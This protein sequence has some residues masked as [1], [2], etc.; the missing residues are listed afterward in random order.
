MKTGFFV[1]I[2][3]LLGIKVTMAQENDPW[4]GTWTSESYSDVDFENSPKDSRGTF[5]EIVYTKYKKVF[6]ITKTGDHYYVRGKTIKVNDSNYSSYHRPYTI[7]SIEGNT[8]RLIS[9]VTKSP[10]RVNGQID[11]YS[12]ITYYYKLTLTNGVLHYTFI[13][14][15]SIDYDKNMRYT[16]EEDYDASIYS[17]RDY[18]L[19]FFND[20]W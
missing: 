20:D 18:D 13:S 14:Y 11:S 8:M 2:L 15:H 6:R 3:S 16:G 7:T 19:N 4:V 12:D 9:S 17:H 1:C 10:F 5:T